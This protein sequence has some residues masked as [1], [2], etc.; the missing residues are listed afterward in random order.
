MDDIL[1]RAVKFEFGS[2]SNDW[3][4]IFHVKRQGD[5][6]WNVKDGAFLYDINSDVFVLEYSEFRNDPEFQ[7][8][9]RFTLDDAFRIAETIER[10]GKIAFQ[11]RRVKEI[12]EWCKQNGYE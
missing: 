12:K 9:T 6:E 1:K 2:N 8:D 4:D 3:H 11:R 7:K 10:E 5:S